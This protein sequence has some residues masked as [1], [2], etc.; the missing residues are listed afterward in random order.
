MTNSEEQKPLPKPERIA[1]L[2]AWRQAFI[3]LEA[4]Y[5]TLVSTIGCLSEDTALWKA[6]YGTFAVYTK[7]LGKVLG[8]QAEWLEWFCWENAMGSKGMGAK[9]TTWK[10]LRKIKTLKD[11]D[12]LMQ[13]K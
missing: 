7:V 9:A 3:D 1:L 8:D 13:D 6:M 5:A 2:T 12:N 10:R 11:L 4:A